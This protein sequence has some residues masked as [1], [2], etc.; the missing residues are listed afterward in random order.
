MKRAMVVGVLLGGLAASGCVIREVRV[1]DDGNESGRGGAAGA[2]DLEN[3]GCLDEPPQQTSQ[4]VFVE[5]QLLVATTAGV[6]VTSAIV[7]ACSRLEFT[8]CNNPLGG[9]FPVDSSGKV[10]VPV[11][12]NFDG[13]LEV[14]DKDSRLD[15]N[16]KFIRSLVFFPTR[17]VIR[18]AV[19]RGIFVLDENTVET[20]AALV[21]GTFDQTTGIVALSTLNCESAVAPGV[22]YGIP[23]M[24]ITTPLT[25]GFYTFDTLPTQGLT[26]TDKS[27]LGGYTNIT[28]GPA[29]FT[30]TLNAQQRLITDESGTGVFVRAGWYTQV[31]I[32][33]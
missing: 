7:R 13:Y 10:R 18:G 14:F 1:G 26:E 33:P 12:Q 24:S 29:A 11:P 2:V 5:L 28:A 9:E 30:A 31:H 8:A 17:E 4:N 3:W 15:Y 6:P 32:S 21:G 20:L 23:N 25:K 27:G 16:P 22:S 19:G